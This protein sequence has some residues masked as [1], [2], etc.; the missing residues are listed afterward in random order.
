MAQDSPLSIAG[1]LTGILTFVFAVIAG[2]YARAIS[3]R[4]AIDTQAEVS[5][6]LEKIDF[7]ETETD[8][9]NSAFLASQIRHPDRTY[10]KGDFKY[11][12]GLYGQSLN[13]MR[14]MD[15]ELSKSAAL[16]TGGNRYDKI[17]RVKTAAAW[18]SARNQ[19][20]K[21][22]EERKA[23]SHRIFQIQLAMLSAKIDE[24]SYHQSHHNHN[25]NIVLEEIGSLQRYLLQVFFPRA[26]VR[27]EMRRVLC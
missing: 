16:V 2:F 18:M 12:Q 20:H 8:M 9:L 15:R 6:A 23:E 1:S 17:S 10:G 24:L 13:R 22:I 7:L 21:D 26:G 14:K 5:S 4:S 11:F 3:L 27:N 19:M 25:C